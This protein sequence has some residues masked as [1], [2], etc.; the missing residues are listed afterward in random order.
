MDNLQLKLR[1][2]TTLTF[3][4]AGGDIQ[5]QWSLRLRFL[6]EQP[7]VGRPDERIIGVLQEESRVKRAW[8]SFEKH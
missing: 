7:A 8:K 4:S 5:H 3:G 1:S 2:G 6:R